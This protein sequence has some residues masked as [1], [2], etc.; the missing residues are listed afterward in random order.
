MNSKYFTINSHIEILDNNVMYKSIIQDNDDTS[1]TINTPCF[2]NKYYPL[3]PGMKIS[4]LV[5]KDAYIL[6]Y[7]GKV[8]EE[9]N[10]GAVRLFRI[11][12][13]CFIKK[14]QRRSYYRHP[15][16]LP[17]KYC[18]VPTHLENLRVSQILNA[19]DTNMI[20]S[21]TRDI[22]GGGLRIVLKKP[23]NLNDKL[24]V[25][26]KLEEM[27]FNVLCSIVRLYKEDETDLEIAGLKYINIDENT[28]DKII[29]FIFKKNVASKN[30]FK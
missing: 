30:L 7:S 11:C 3:H 28:R 10:E 25:S 9:K 20:N 2:G 26:F 12:D 13:I 15:I 29:R 18:L 17:V 21:V 24:L 22:S 4:F 8:T 19:L 23:C 5:I 14:I 6:E 27:D 16:A 1:I